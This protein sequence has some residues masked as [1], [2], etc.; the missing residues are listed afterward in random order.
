MAK[1]LQW[2]QLNSEAMM[3]VAAGWAAAR[4]GEPFDPVQS[5]AW[6]EAWELYWHPLTQA[7]LSSRQS[8]QHKTS[9]LRETAR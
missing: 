1:Q 8:Q 6:R 4:E 7:H 5:Q 9:Q 3:K 2:H